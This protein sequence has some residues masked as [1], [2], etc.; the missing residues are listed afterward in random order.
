MQLSRTIGGCALVCLATACRS[1][2]EGRLWIGGDVHLGNGTAGLSGL[3]DRLQGDPLVVN[4][5]G[6]IG[7]GE[8]WERSSDRIVLRNLPAAVVSLPKQGV[9]AA[10]I[11]NN[12]AHDLGD[13]APK[14]TTAALRAD[15]I[16]PFGGPAGATVVDVAGLR[17]VLTAHDLS[18]GLPP[19]LKEDLDT[20]RTK[21]DAMV[22]TFHTSDSSTYLP[23]P[24]VRRA[25]QIALSEGA[26]AVAV[27]GSHDLGPVERRGGAVVA[28]GLGNLAFACDCTDETSG[29]LLELTFR[30]GAGLISAAAVPIDA[31]LH[32][33][34]ASF[35]RDPE[36]TFDLLAAL[37]SSPL[38]RHG[39]IASF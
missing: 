6:P 13:D 18:Q 24:D 33:A 39:P 4:L 28:F 12:H 32:G 31:G 30:R 21:G 1:R 10:G 16:A 15:G 25:T 27:H 36:G 37:G 19:N 5:E 7:E 29:L 14:K 2:V 20:A 35:A 9:R 3:K 23:S 34:S 22:A 17:V 26:V 11:A 8:A 38:Q